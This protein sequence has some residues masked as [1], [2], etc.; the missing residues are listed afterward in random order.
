MYL[1]KPSKTCWIR[2]MLYWFAS[3]RTW[4]LSIWWGCFV[5]DV[6][7]FPTKETLICFYLLW[8]RL[9]ICC[10]T[11]EVRTA[12]SIA[13]GWVSAM[14]AAGPVQ[15]SARMHWAPF[16]S[17]SQERLGGGEWTQSYS[18]QGCPCRDI[19]M[20]KESLHNLR[21]PDDPVHH[22]FANRNFSGKQR[23]EMLI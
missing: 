8:F 20:Q 22:I 7:S 11:P 21:K 13:S 5:H 18:V 3:A 23:T 1:L 15:S 9:E 17:F 10:L 4:G 19:G 6:K 14:L 16:L 2:S 12:F